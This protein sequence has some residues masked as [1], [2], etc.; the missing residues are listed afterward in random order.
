MRALIFRYVAA[1]DWNGTFNL[2]A[3]QGGDYAQAIL[4]RLVAIPCK[5]PGDRRTNAA[6]LTGGFP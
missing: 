4:E 3:Q 2:I 6:P 5:S 1:S